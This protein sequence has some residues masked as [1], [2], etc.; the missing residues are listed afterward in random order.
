MVEEMITGSRDEGKQQTQAQQMAG[1]E[2]V[3]GVLTNDD[4]LKQAS[5][6]ED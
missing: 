4:K 5:K 3:F 2:P 6:V 1:A